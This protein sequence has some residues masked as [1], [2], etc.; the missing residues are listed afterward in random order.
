MSETKPDKKLIKLLLIGDGKSGKTRYAAEAA[1]QG[2]NVLYMDGDVG[3]PT[4]TQVSMDAQRR[5]YLLPMHDKI[6]MGQRDHTFADSLYT[7]F[8]QAKFNWNDDDCR[9]AKRG[10][11]DKNK[12]QILPA[13]MDQN[14]VLVIDSWTSYIESL[15]LKVAI[16]CSVDLPTA[17]QPQMRP[18]YAGAG[19]RATAL[20]QVIRAVPCHV[21]VIAHSDEYQH[22]VAPEGRRA[23]DV[24]ETEMEIAWTK[25]IPKSTSKPHGLLLPKYFTDVAWL[26]LKPSGKRELRF[27]PDPDRVGGGHFQQDKPVEEYSF[28]NL[29]REIG[30]A[31]PIP[32]SPVNHWLTMIPAGTTI[33]APAK[34]LDGTKST[35]VKG[36]AGLSALKKA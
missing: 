10:D 13:K 28:L 22:K 30:G 3:T 25:M 32:D 33:E 6:D 8:S 9:V 26:G 18:V 7:F 19:A 12:W 16:E 31:D 36:L 23:G 20:L 5:I 35:P 4:L 21:I 17:T 14:C 15:M 11:D 29:V 24:K 34:V 2:F 1:E 27:K